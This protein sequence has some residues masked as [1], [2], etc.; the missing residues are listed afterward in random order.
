MAAA[1]Q[2]LLEGGAG[3]A[4]VPLLTDGR[5]GGRGPPLALRLRLQPGEGTNPLPTEVCNHWLRCC[6]AQQLRGH[7]LLVGR[8]ASAISAW[9]LDLC[10]E[11]C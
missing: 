1:Q 5:E 8:I 2:R 9:R 3:R 10:R 4:V 7:R 6:I 11:G